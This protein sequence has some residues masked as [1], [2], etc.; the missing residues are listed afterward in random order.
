MIGTKNRET[1]AEDEKKRE[2]EAEKEALA[3]QL[4]TK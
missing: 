4:S 1:K 2:T 3:H